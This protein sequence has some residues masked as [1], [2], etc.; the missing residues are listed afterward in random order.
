MIHYAIEIQACAHNLYP[1]GTLLECDTVN[2]GTLAAMCDETGFCWH[3]Q[4]GTEKPR[5][6][7]KGLSKYGFP[8]NA[9]VI[10]KKEV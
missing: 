9:R 7:Y 10:V 4:G 3:E 1:D 2:P 8:F 5:N 6:V